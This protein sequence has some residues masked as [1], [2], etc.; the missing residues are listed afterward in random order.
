MAENPDRIHELFEI[1][2]KNS[3]GV[4]AA[5]MWLLGMPIT[6]VVDDYLPLDKYSW[7]EYAT[8]Y[9]KVGQDGALWGPLMEKF[10]AKFLGNYEIVDAGIASDGIEW[11]TGAPSRWYYNA[12]AESLGVDLWDEMLKADERGDMIS[13]GTEF[14]TGTDQESNE[15]GLP[16]MHAFSVMKLL[17]VTDQFGTDHRLVQMRNPWG[18]EWYYGDWSDSASDRWT[19]DLRQQADHYEAN[20]GKFFMSYEDYLQYVELTEIN[21]NVDG[22]QHTSFAKFN[23]TEPWNPKQVFWRDPTIYNEHKLTI[24]SA[25]R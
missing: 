20:D 4:Y 22:M 10:S 2:Q 8:R 12:E 21:M 11:M 16:Y 23:D 9:A 18:E 13:A 7:D 25:V 24:F 3:V 6:V 5:Q 19:D 17:T 15:V 1:E 14:G